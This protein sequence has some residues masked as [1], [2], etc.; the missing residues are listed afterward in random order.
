MLLGIAILFFTTFAIQAGL[1][2]D[3]LNCKLFKVKELAD[4]HG[5]QGPLHFGVKDSL[6]VYI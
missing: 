4:L 1:L 2:G 6:F 5:R 3:R